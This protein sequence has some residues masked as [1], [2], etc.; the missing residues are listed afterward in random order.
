MVAAIGAG[1]VD[2][3]PLRHTFITGG[4]AREMTI[5]A[6]VLI[7]GHIHKDESFSVVTKG[8][9][10][11]LTEH[12][13]C[14]IHAPTTVFAS[15]AGTKRIGYAHTETVWTT[16]HVTDETDPDRMIEVLTVPSYEEWVKLKGAVL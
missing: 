16:I 6:G 11:V 4:Y 2:D 12:G 8:H 1:I 13:V 7:I 14:D 5:P 3:L 9:I 15:P 10:T